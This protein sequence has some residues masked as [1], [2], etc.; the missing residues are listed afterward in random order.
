MLALLLLPSSYAFHSPAPLPSS[1]FLS[2]TCFKTVRGKGPLHVAP[3]SLPRGGT[4]ALRSTLTDQDPITKDVASSLKQE[5]TKLRNACGE[6]ELSVLNALF[7]RSPDEASSV[8]VSLSS[9]LP[10]DLPAGALLRVGPN[11]RPGDPV[12]G[13]FD[14][15]GMIH[16]VVIPPSDQGKGS[17]HVFYGR[18]WVRTRAFKIEEEK[19]EV[20][21]QGIMCAPRGWPIVKGLMSNF[22]RTGYPLKDTANTALSFHAGPLSLRLEEGC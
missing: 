17:D 1:S 4:F 10:S 5:M 18:K 19:Q 21:F 15:D 20:L 8:R 16:G 11:P 22:I 13:F 7:V 9:P 6:K 12:P 3:R 14:G 2:R